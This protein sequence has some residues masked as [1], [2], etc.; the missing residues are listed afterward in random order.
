MGGGVDSRFG[1]DDSFSTGGPRP[2]FAARGAGPAYLCFL[3]QPHPPD[4]VYLREILCAEE[5]LGAD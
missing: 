5:M 2:N 1:V 3:A 4:V